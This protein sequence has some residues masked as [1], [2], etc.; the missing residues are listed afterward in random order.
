ML[1]EKAGALS[2]I[3]DRGRFGY[4]S[5]GIGQAGAM[6]TCAYEAGALLTENEGTAAALEMTLLG[7][8]FRFAE[9]AVIALTG[10]DM[11]ARLNGHS[12]PPYL[13]CAVMPDDTLV[14]SMAKYGCRA[15]L[16]IHGGFDVP[17]V[18]GSRSTDLKCRI[19]G[20][21]GR[22]LRAG[23]TLPAVPSPLSRSLEAVSLANRKAV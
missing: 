13:A 19:G 8:T 5:S 2:T 3:Q 6:D 7:G 1:I 16:S 23:D 4:L 11:D 15:Y 17:C 9:E 20:I 18:L 14:L 10:A 22:A 12:L 21:G